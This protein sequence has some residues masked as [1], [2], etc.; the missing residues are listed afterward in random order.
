LAVVLASSL[1]ASGGAELIPLPVMT[2]I[3]TLA[4]CAIPMGLM[5]SG[6]IIIEYAGDFIRGPSIGSSLPVIGSAIAIR[7]LAMPILMLGATKL[8]ANGLAGTHMIEVMTIQAAMPV[9]IFPIVLVRLY[10]RD[11]RTAIEVIVS[12][13]IAGIITIPVWLAIGTWWLS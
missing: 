7:Q 1:R 9:A 11:T 6:A 3:S 10:D 12:T 2:A 8:L 13:S 4:A 5:L